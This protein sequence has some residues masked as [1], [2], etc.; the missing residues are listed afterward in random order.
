MKENFRLYETNPRHFFIKLFLPFLF[1]ILLSP[2]SL[3]QKTYHGC[4]MEG[5]A[6]SKKVRE[7]NELK[8]RYNFPKEKDMD[9]SV[10]LKAMLKPGNDIDRWHTNKAAQVTGYVYNVK[11]GG[12]ESCN[13]EA[14]DK[15]YRDTHIELVLNPDKTAENQR[16]IVEITPRIRALM[17]DKGIDWTTKSLRQKYLGRWIK[18][19]G[20][21]LFDEEHQRQA[22]N[23]NPGNPKDWRA[24]A[25]EIHPVTGIEAV[26]RH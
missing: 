14:K 2:F 18:V 8:N 9:K 10:T 24:T 26:S 1:V 12:V 5:T 4:G 15:L 3:A 17:K 19:Q 16:I 23:T 21:L 13:C 7:L 6:R 11:P 20:W 25:W 22:E